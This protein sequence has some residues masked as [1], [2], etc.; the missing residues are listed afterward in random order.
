LKRLLSLYSNQIIFLFLLLIPVLYLLTLARG[1]VLGDPT[2]FTFVANILGIAH[3]PGYAFITLLGKVFQTVI[4][5]GDIPW[6]MHLLSAV[7]ATLGAVFVFGII[8][9]LSKRFP[10]QQ[11]QFALLAAL[12]AALSVGFSADIWQHAIHA[13]PH[14]IT[15]VFLVANLFFLTKWYTGSLLDSE[16]N[17]GR[18]NWL[19]VFCVSAGLGL[20]HHPLTVFG[21]PA[22]TLFILWAK[23]RI[24]RQGWL[25]LKM[26]LGALW[27]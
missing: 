9:A 19:L 5:F 20:T 21:F 7:S 25:L 13:N 27:G 10:G 16:G 24:L 17:G 6:R 12:F 4:P 23:P 8:Q 1:L 11:N 26:I 22:Y 18:V 15:A 14:I 3:P 2:E